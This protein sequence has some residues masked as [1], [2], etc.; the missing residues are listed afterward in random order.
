MKRW[1]TSPA[2][3]APTTPRRVPPSFLRTRRLFAVGLHRSPIHP[4]ET[5]VHTGLPRSG[6]PVS[7][8]YYRTSRKPAA[9]LRTEWDDDRVGRGPVRPGAMRPSRRRHA[10]LDVEVIKTVVD[11]AGDL[12]CGRL[13]RQHRA[14]RV[15]HWPVSARPARPEHRLGQI[16]VVRAPWAGGDIAGSLRSAARSRSWTAL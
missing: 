4:I 2:G 16:F 8:F 1:R 12:G 6:I 15:Q 9:S 13:V 14:H 3:C 7:T 10:D 11:E 5:R